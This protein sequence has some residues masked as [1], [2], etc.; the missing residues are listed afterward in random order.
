MKFFLI[1]VV[2]DD[3]FTPGDIDTLQDEL[4]QVFKAWQ[5]A[6]GVVFEFSELME[7]ETEDE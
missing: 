3:E 4:A 5:N 7:T 2:V 6:A 1:S